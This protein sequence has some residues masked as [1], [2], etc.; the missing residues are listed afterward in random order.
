MEVTF[1]LK[2]G[3]FRRAV[4]RAAKELRL[5]VTHDAGN[6]WAFSVEAGGM[7]NVY[8]FGRR[9]YRLLARAQKARR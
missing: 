7:S 9:T 2:P 4:L 1:Q 3:V 8:E 5:S 6:P